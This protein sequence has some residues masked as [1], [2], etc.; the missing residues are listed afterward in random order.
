MG[1]RQCV[2]A[3]T[4]PNPLKELDRNYQLLSHK[5]N[6][7]DFIMWLNKMIGRKSQELR[8]KHRQWSV[9]VS[10]VA[11]N[12][13]IWAFVY[14]YSNWNNCKDLQ[15]KFKSIYLIFSYY[16]VVYNIILFSSH[17]NSLY[18]FQ[19]S[20]FFYFAYTKCSLE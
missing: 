8:D 7:V 19:F 14:K 16:F 20:F 6:K 1:I 15:L 12:R 17:S 18:L 13:H 2:L 4:K 3:N 11:S 9:I 10:V 5:G